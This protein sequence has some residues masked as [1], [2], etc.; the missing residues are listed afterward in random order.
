MKRPSNSEP[1]NILGT[2][3][4]LSARMKY[5][6][7]IEIMDS[8]LRSIRSGATKTHIM[9]RAYMSYAQLKE[10]LALLQERNLIAFDSQSQLFTLT[11]KGLKFLNTYET[12]EELVPNV[13]DRNVENKQ[14]VTVD[15]FSY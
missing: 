14:A 3:L 12:I 4:A 15:S 10:Y 9:Y 6:S 2:I 5:R 13:V 1:Y 11:E 8:V 7:R